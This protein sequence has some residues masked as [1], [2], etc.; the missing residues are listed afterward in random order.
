MASG[1]V[2][3]DSGTGQILAQLNGAPPV[4]AGCV[5]S[6]LGGDTHATCEVSG[7][8]VQVLI[9]AGLANTAPEVKGFRP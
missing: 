6:N 1:A 7:A 2:L 8:S 5:R 4:P 9:N 3:L